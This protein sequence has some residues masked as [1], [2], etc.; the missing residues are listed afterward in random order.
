MSPA[1]NR[2]LIHD[3]HCT[4]TQSRFF[5]REFFGLTGTL[6]VLSLFPCLSSGTGEREIE[7]ADQTVSRRKRVYRRII[8]SSG[9]YPL[10]NRKSKGYYYHGCMQIHCRTFL[11]P[12]LKIIL[13][14]SLENIFQPPH[15]CDTSLNTVYI[16]YQ[17]FTRVDNY[18]GIH[19][20]HHSIQHIL[21]TS[22]QL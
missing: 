2:P 13:V 11:F 21:C 4:R 19:L 12:M 1:V 10:K 15:V 9:C 5:S 14:F 16:K 17:Y 3:M 7:I 22:G 8:T 6:L 20:P 18:F